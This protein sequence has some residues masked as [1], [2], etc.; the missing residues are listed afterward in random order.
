MANEKNEIK[1]KP[2][3][4]K[5]ITHLNR[6]EVGED[7]HIVKEVSYENN[8]Y[9]DDIKIIK[10][11]KRPFWVTNEAYRNHKLKKEAEDIKKVTMFKST[12]SNLPY[13]IPPRLGEEYANVNNLNILRN[14]PYIYGID[15]DSRTFLKRYYNKKNN[16]HKSPYRYG[17]FDIETNTIKDEIIV[18][19]VTTN[20][21]CNVYINKDLVKK[22]N[23]P[24]SKLMELYKKHIPDNELKDNIN[25]KFKIYDT[26]LEMLMACLKELNYLN[27]DICGIWNIKYDIPKIMER[28]DHY[29]V[30]YSDAFHYDKIPDKY[31]FFKFKEGQTSKLTASNKYSPINP[32]EQ[33]HTVKSTTNY[34]FLDAM[35]THRFV[36]TGGK[37]I[38][39]GYSLGN[40]LKHEKIPGKLYF[41]FE[42]IAGVEGSLEWHIWMVENRPLE[43][44]IYNVWDTMSMVL[45][46]N[47]TKDIKLT[48]PLLAGVSHFD[49]FNSGP[50]KIIDALEF[51]VLGKGKVLGTKPGFSKK[52][53]SASGGYLGLDGWINTM[54]SYRIDDNGIK[55]LIENP[56]LPTNIRLLTYDSDVVSSYPSCI[57]SANVSK[58]TTNREVIKIGDIPKD[59]FKL[60]N[61]NLMYGATNAVEYCNVMFNMPDTYELL[62][63]VA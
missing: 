48:M 50:K 45:L 32:E 40:I 42:D 56:D 25:V 36:R 53:D 46:D 11:F 33:W 1:E 54:P 19:S 24:I 61:M 63:N 28:L 30:K 55:A 3:E 26:E 7:I 9:T 20:K 10:N 29:G 15:V 2:I 22:I 6:F 27:I 47:K 51:Y 17:A 16:D 38:P 4:A 21:L 14:S 34:M 44:I 12:E 60:Q 59:T 62:E 58:D 18:I 43:Y 41:D 37:T 57:M 23:A 5:I 52:D 35:S 13:A 31:K 39:G 8:K 49:I